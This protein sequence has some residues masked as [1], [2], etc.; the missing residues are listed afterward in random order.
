MGC[1]EH[2]TPAAPQ[3]EGWPHDSSSASTALRRSAEIQASPGAVDDVEAVARLVAQTREVDA[4]QAWMPFFLKALVLRPHPC[5]R[6]RPPDRSDEGDELGEQELGQ[7]GANDDLQDLDGGDRLGRG[8]DD[9]NRR[10]VSAGRLLVASLAIATACSRTFGVRRWAPFSSALA[11]EANIAAC[12]ASTSA[13]AFASGDWAATAAASRRAA[14]ALSLA[15]RWCAVSWSSA[16]EYRA[17]AI[18]PPRTSS[19]PVT[20]P[21]FESQ[22]LLLSGMPAH[23]P[24]MGM[25]SATAKPA[26]TGSQSFMPGMGERSASACIRSMKKPERSLTTAAFGHEEHRRGRSRCLPDV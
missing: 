11:E 23:A 26:K 1:D 12:A 21:C 8:L 14:R 24:L 18:A 4:V 3:R 13:R 25:S 9:G 20:L 6:G 19:R 5:E 17:S 7:R 16:F 15:A 22:P 10:L 2:T